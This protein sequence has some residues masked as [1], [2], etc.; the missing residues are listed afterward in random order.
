MGEEESKEEKKEASSIFPCVKSVTIVQSYHRYLSEGLSDGSM[1]G[2][3]DQFWK[4]ET[5]QEGHVVIA[6]WVAWVAFC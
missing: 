6:S 4:G 3:L 1:F 5:I 2:L